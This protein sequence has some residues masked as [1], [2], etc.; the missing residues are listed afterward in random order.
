M[1]AEQIGSTEAVAKL[2]RAN[3]A[4]GGADTHFGMYLKTPGEQKPLDGAIVAVMREA[5]VGL[6]LGSSLGGSR[7][8]CDPNCRA[9]SS[10]NPPHHHTTTRNIETPCFNDHPSL[11]LTHACSSDL[12]HQRHK[13][14]SDCHR[15]GLSVASSRLH[16]GTVTRQYHD[17]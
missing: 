13:H 12:V 11:I 8:P 10:G 14:S 2:R 5:D 15:S 17:V 4:A 6:M 1:F 7:A 9:V 3:G 16:C